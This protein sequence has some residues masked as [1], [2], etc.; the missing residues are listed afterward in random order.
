[1]PSKKTPSAPPST[2]PQ[3]AAQAYDAI[4]ANVDAMPETEVR[5]VNV[6]IPRAVSVVLGALVPMRAL[7]A[8]I[9][10]EI[11]AHPIGSLHQLEQ[12]ALGAWYAYLLALPETGDLSAV[13]RLT[14]EGAPLREGLLVGAEALAAR[15]I[16]DPVTVAEIRSGQGNLDMANDL[17]ALSA[18]FTVHAE[19]VKGKTAVTEAE[20][21]RAASL[22]PELLAAL[23]T[24]RRVGAAAARKSAERR[25]R[26]FTLM[27]DAYDDCRRA[28]AYLRWKQGDADEIAPSI[29]DTRSARRRKAAESGEPEG[30]PA[31]ESSPEG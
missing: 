25:A 21:A 22:G 31:P 4:L 23:G 2:P 12:L 10:R 1:M 16:L 27:V 19:A 9:E 26:A 28:V 17:V 14:E 18:L 29:F 30:E 8:D 13:T 5:H 3:Q 7:Q 11:P 6:D 15:G 24:R 20:V